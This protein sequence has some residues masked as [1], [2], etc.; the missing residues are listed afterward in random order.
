VRASVPFFVEGVD[1]DEDE[2]EDGGARPTAIGPRG[3]LP[4]TQDIFTRL[5]LP[6]G[7]DASAPGFKLLLRAYLA[8]YPDSLWPDAGDAV[9]ALGLPVAA[10][11][12]AVTTA[13]EHAV[14]P[15]LPSGVASYASLARAI[16]VRDPALFMPGTPNVDWRQHVRVNRRTEA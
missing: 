10:T 11:R 8:T 12:I 4:F 2:E 1:E 16:A 15:R 6:G 3:P 13:F 14:A 7:G 5:K 9:A